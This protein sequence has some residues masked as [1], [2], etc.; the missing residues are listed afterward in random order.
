MGE[1]AFVTKLA[2]FEYTKYVRYAD[3]GDLLVIKAENAGPNGYRVTDYSHVHASSV[4][5]LTRSKLVGGEL[6]MVFVGAG[7]GNVAIVPQEQRFFLA[8]ISA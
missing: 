7:T 4:A 5:K 1:F 3:D 2:G 8:Q 6:L